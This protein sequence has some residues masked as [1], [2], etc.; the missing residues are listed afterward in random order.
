MSGR[1]MKVLLAASLVL[2]LF[3]VG[4]VGGVMVIRHGAMVRAAAGDPLLTAADSLAPAQHNAFRAMIAGQLAAIR[5]QLRDARQARRQ[6]V[7]Q[8]EA[9]PFDRAAAGA[10]LAR[11]RAD[12]AAARG[13][14]EEAILSFAAQLPP[15]ERLA[16]ANGLRRAALARWLANH[17]GARQST[18]G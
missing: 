9:D 4:A 13:Q 8:I 2:N 5:P 1:W 12:D 7:A 10:N 6:A 11:A 3:F 16:F 18:G 14:I 17:P 15:T